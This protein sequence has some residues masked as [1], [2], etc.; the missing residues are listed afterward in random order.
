MK[1]SAWKLPADSL[2]SLRRA[3]IT[4]PRMFSLYPAQ[5]K[6]AQEISDLRQ[7]IAVVK[8]QPT[9]KVPVLRFCAAFPA[10]QG[11]VLCQFNLEIM[12]TGASRVQ[13]TN[14]LSHC[15]YHFSDDVEKFRE[16]FITLQ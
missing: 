1:S 14:S 8:A 7:R 11:E 9:P 10:V 12:C 15:I 5:G 13:T 4:K 3:A 2:S 6:A 16:L